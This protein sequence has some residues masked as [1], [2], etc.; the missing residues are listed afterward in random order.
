L[1]CGIALLLLSL[2]GTGVFYFS[3]RTLNSDLSNQKLNMDQL[4]IE[5][6]LL[7]K[8]LHAYKDNVNDLKGDNQNL[9]NI[10]NSVKFQ[11]TKNLAEIKNL[12][13]ENSAVK[14]LRQQ[15]ADMKQTVMNTQNMAS[16]D[17]KRMQSEINSLNSTISSFQEDNKE[18]AANVELLRSVTADNFHLKATRRNE[19]LTVVA[20]RTRQIKVSFDMPQGIEADIKFNITK[21]DGTKLSGAN[22]GIAFIVFENPDA[23]LS[24][25]T[26]EATG[27]KLSKKVEMTYKPKAKLKAGDYIIEMT[28]KNMHVA[29]CHVKLR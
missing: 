9:Q 18:L 21:P 5:K 29:Y 28:N 10:L 12:K 8:E 1:V 4:L 23:A 25:S 26:N 19:K 27:L 20:R 24:A 3:N 15:L 16:A 17:K 22:D 2:I 7:N 6:T 14:S 11:E 13:R